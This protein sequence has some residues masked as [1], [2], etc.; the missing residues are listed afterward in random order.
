[1]APEDP[2]GEVLDARLAP[3]LQ[4]EDVGTALG[5]SDGRG[6][7]GHTRTDDDDIEV[8]GHGGPRDGGPR[9]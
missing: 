8:V 3:S 1:M 2:A 6:G 9:T 5:Q 4:E 7:P